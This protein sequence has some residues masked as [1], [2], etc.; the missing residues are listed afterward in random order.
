MKRE[1]MITGL[2]VALFSLVFVGAFFVQ[3][4][5]EKA[6]ELGYAIERNIIS[7]SHQLDPNANGG[8][9]AALTSEDRL[10]DLENA[11]YYQMVENDYIHIN[12]GQMEVASPAKSRTGGLCAQDKHNQSLGC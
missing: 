12:D 7:S 8:S 6:A 1:K 11:Y 2:S 3:G 5:E 10:E 4:D 9:V